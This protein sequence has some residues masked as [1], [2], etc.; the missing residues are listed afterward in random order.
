MALK[1]KVSVDLTSEKLLKLDR[2]ELIADLTDKEIAFCENYIKDYNIKLAAIRAGIEPKKANNVG[3]IF[4]KRPKVNN[5]IAWLKMQLYQKANIDAL[6]I[7]N[8]YAKA[9]FS[10]ITDYVD[11]VNGRT[12]KLKPI[13]CVDG[14]LIQELS[15]N[16]AGGINIKL[17]DKMQAFN[18][19]ESYMDTN[20]Y[21]WKRKLEERKVEIMEERLE[22]DKKKFDPTDDIDEGD[23]GLISALIKAANGIFDDDELEESEEE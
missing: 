18:R 22:L 2:E 23:D 7:L 13:E 10:D 15:Q 17:I 19:L 12:L 14:Q 3:M 21:D 9:A 16:V 8:F 11:V 6:D 4:R 20:Q 1:K 5:Y